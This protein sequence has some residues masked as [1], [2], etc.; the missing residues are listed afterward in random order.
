MAGN[1]GHTYGL[2]LVCA[3][4]AGCAGRCHRADSSSQSGP[5]TANVDLGTPA[6]AE[7]VATALALNVCNGSKYAFPSGPSYATQAGAKTLAR[8]TTWA[9]G[10][11]GGIPKRTTICQTL[12]PSGKADDAAIN[13]AIQKC[14]DNQ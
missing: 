4:L 10:I 14:P 12:S 9:P 11:P 7:S 5:A 2:A 13:D 3:L 1:V 8:V 6:P